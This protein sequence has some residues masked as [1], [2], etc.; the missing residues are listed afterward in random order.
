LNNLSRPI[1]VKTTGKKPAYRSLAVQLVGYAYFTRDKRHMTHQELEYIRQELGVSRSAMANLL[2]C[3]YVGY[4]RYS[5]GA[6]PVPRYIARGCLAL[7]FIN[8]NGMLEEYEE[9]LKTEKL[10]PATV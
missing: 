1:G 4:K 6:R 2:Q 10:L 5:I 3:D 9:F 7:L 8:G